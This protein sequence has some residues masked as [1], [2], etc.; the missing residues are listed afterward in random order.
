MIIQ[1]YWITLSSPTYSIL[2]LASDLYAY[3][4]S[5]PKCLSSPLHSPLFLA[6][7]C[8]HH[9]WFNLGITSSTCQYWIIAP[10]SFIPIKVLTALDHLWLLMEA[11]W[12]KILWLVYSA[13]KKNGV[14]WWFNTYWQ[15][16][17]IKQTKNSHDTIRLLFK[18]FRWLISWLY[19]IH[20]FLLHNK[21]CLYPSKWCPTIDTGV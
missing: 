14:W 18:Y 1:P 10:T 16:Q 6:D 15:H 13:L 9:S 11:L 8:S 17:W 4:P 7:N 12:W 20:A 21:C 5:A 19:V 2:S 3:F